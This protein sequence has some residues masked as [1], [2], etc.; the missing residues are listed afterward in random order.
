MFVAIVPTYNRPKM[1]L[2]NVAALLSQTRALDAIVLVDNASGPDTREALSAAGYLANDRIHYVRIDDNAGASG[3]FKRGLEVALEMGA[4]WIWG[5]DDDAFP[6]PEALQ[7]L[8]DAGLDENVCYWSNCDRDTEFPAA[9]KKVEDL[10]FVGFF[11]HRDLL[12]KVGFPDTRYY[13]Y[14]DD[15]DFSNRIYGAG[16]QI[17][18]VRD[19]LINHDD[20]RTRGEKPFTDFRVLGVKVSIFN[21]DPHRLYYMVRNEFYIQKRSVSNALLW[22]ARKQLVLA[23]Y[24][25]FRRQCVYFV[26]VALAD[27]IMNRRGKKIF[28]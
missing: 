21:G 15:V 20:W 4:Q 11:L 7:K 8:I 22:F 26:A 18:K 5:M 16:A 28:A 13:M 9:L 10:M 23:K 19:S 27:V 14:Y 1:L 3:G 2:E 12:Q 25:L 17:L 6:T 24:F